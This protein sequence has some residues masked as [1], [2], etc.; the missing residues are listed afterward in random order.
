MK[1]LMAVVL[2]AGSSLLQGHAMA[3]GARGAGRSECWL[4]NACLTV[5][6][7]FFD[8]VSPPARRRNG[9]SRSQTSSLPVHAA[10]AQP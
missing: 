5:A 4:L 8:A 6:W 9:L 3:K 7:R 10:T 2:A 1:V